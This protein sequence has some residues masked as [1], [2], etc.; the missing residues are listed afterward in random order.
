MAGDT[1]PRPG[2]V[3]SRAPHLAT[4]LCQRG[5]LRRWVMGSTWTRLRGTSGQQLAEFALVIGIVAIVA[6]SMQGPARRSL[7]RGVQAVSDAVFGP[8]PPPDNP[9]GTRDIRVVASQAQTETSLGGFV[10]QTTLTEGGAGR[11]RSED[12][13]TSVV[14]DPIGAASLGTGFAG[15]H[16]L[17]TS[18]NAALGRAAGVAAN[19]PLA[20][21]V[22]T[23]SDGQRRQ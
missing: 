12:V 23:T 8:P 20:P 17:D 19:V 18:L 6:I 9:Q 5:R 13:I 11:A 7:Q 16:A 22:P 3:R 15:T 4:P 21:N 2:G 10:R 1:R 14:V